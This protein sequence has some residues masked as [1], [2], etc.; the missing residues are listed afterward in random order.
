MRP[1]WSTWKVRGYMVRLYRYSASDK[2]SCTQVLCPEWHVQRRAWA[3][4]SPDYPIVNRAVEKWGLSP[5]CC[6]FQLGRP[7]QQP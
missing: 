4:K 1:A 6:H 3:K 5:L 2:P 7:V